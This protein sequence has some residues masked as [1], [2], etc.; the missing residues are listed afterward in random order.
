MV[1]QV[2]EGLR[3]GL[4]ALYDTHLAADG[5]SVD[6]KGLGADLDF[7]LFVDATAELQKLDISAFNRPERMAFWINMYNV[8]VVRTPK[9]LEASLT[10]HDVR[11]WF[12]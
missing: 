3:R 4:L 7:Q 12:T 1:P 11:S 5:K 10:D 8:L 9:P 2:A 6:Y